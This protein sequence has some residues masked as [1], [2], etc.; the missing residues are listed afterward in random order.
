MP[1]S[2]IAIEERCL[3]CQLCHTVV[4]LR[5]IALLRVLGRPSA[6]QQP[7][8]KPANEAPRPCERRNRQND[9]PEH[10]TRYR[11]YVTASVT[12]LTPP[13]IMTATS[14]DGHTWSDLVDT[15]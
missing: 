13:K 5:A 2:Q 4:R 6:A 7:Q 9:Q 8:E 12:S 10:H 1:S 14:A 11:M 15:G 3:A